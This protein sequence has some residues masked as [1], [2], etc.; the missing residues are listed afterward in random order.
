[1]ATLEKRWNSEL[2]ISDRR[3]PQVRRGATAN[4]ASIERAFWGLWRIRRRR[5]GSWGFIKPRKTARSKP[6]GVFWGCKDQTE[7]AHSNSKYSGNRPPLTAKLA[8]LPGISLGPSWEVLQR[9]TPLVWNFLMMLKFLF[10]TLRMDL[11]TARR[12]EPGLAVRHRQTGSLGMDIR[13]QG[14]RMH[15]KAYGSKL[16]QHNLQPSVPNGNR[17]P[18]GSTAEIYGYRF[19]DTHSFWQADL[20]NPRVPR[21]FPKAKQGARPVGIWPE[22]AKEHTKAR[23]F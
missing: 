5:S 3:R 7:S 6:I 23:N 19:R 17:W 21:G 18:H 2:L 11:G 22:K 13:A 12:A 10:P 14:S 15:H 20:A 4:P 9:F 1:M 16:V 8:S